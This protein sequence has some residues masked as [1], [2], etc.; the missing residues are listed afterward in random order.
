MKNS[1][2]KGE[3]RESDVKGEKSKKRKKK[4]SK[5]KRNR[6]SLKT[7]DLVVGQTDER[8]RKKEKRT[9]HSSG[10]DEE[11]QGPPESHVEE[12]LEGAL[13]AG[14]MILIDRMSGKVYSGLNRA[15]NGERKV[16]GRIS[17]SGSVVLDKSGKDDAGNDESE[18][19][20]FPFETDADDH[21]E[22][23][24]EAY[25]D[26]LP[27]L[28]DFKKTSSSSGDIF[29]YDPYFCNGTVARNLNLLGFTNVYNRK[30]DCYRCWGSSSYPSHDILITNP[31]YSGDHIEKLIDHVTSKS[32]G[33]RPWMLLMPQWVHKKDYYISKTKG[34]RPFYVVPHK[35]YVYLPPPSFRESKKSDVHKKSSPF[36]SMWFVWG[37]TVQQ[38]EHWLSTISRQITNCDIARSKSALRDLRRKNK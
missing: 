16:I 22:S 14:E 30:E 21:C 10:N 33:N 15:E 27:C 29:I 38:N 24:L 35:R 28:Q 4:K 23:P 20:E 25:Q 17:R 3:E 18:K 9:T 8:P 37:G 26:V 34:I 32:F 7:E 13:V 1:G 2:L 19:P 5:K 12:S 11:A 36:V 6:S 31:P